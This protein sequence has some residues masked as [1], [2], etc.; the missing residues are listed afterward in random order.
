MGNTEFRVGRGADV[1]RYGIYL[2]SSTLAKASKAAWFAFIVF[3]YLINFI[4]F[5]SCLYFFSAAS[6][7]HHHLVD[8]SGYVDTETWN[9]KNAR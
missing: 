9:V 8:S 4:V 1:A 7:H 6:H 2:L 5:C 3:F